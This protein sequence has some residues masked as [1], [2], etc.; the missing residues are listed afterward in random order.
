M[1]IEENLRGSFNLLSLVYPRGLPEEEYYSLLKTLYEDFSNGNFA[2]LI[3]LFTGKE[4]G[5]V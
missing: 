4:Y 2:K 1:Q 5:I 3:S